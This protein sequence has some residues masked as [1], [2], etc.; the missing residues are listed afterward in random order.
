MP[1]QSRRSKAIATA[2]KAFQAVS[3]LL[4][5]E[6]LLDDELET[7]SLDVNEPDPVLLSFLQ[8]F[9]RLKRIKKSRYYMKR[10]WRKSSL[11]TTIF[12]DDL[13]VCEDGS[14]WMNEDEFKRKYRVSRE[15]LDKITATIENNDVFKG[16]RGPDQLPVKY[17]LMI[18]LHYLGKEGESNAS[19]RD[20]FKIAYGSTE[21]ARERVVKALND[22]RHQYITW[23]D[24]EERKQIARRIEKE[25]HLP[26]CVGF[27]DGTLLPLGIAPSSDDAADYHGRKFQYSLTVLVINDDKRRIRAYLSGYPGSTHDNRLWRNMKQNQK[28]DQYFGPTEYVLCDTA[29]ESSDV[30]VSAYKHD[31]GFFTDPVKQHFNDIMS[32][33]RVITEHTMGMWKGRMPFLRNIR[34]LITNQKESLKRILRYIEASV[35][36]HNMLIEFG[37]GDETNGIVPWDIEEETLSDIGDVTRIPER[38]VLDLPLPMGSQSGQRREQLANYVREKVVRRFNYRLDNSADEESGLSDLDSLSNS[39][40]SI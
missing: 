33:P 12:E 15:T 3:A 32:P 16:E 17:Q 5:V 4:I 9:T 37:D 21:K 24:E 38:D 25:F 36:L 11:N 22:L 14:H 8:S 18:L 28:S 20:Q 34:M 26:N 10:F 29:F 1:R 39:L 40:M 19:Q 30:C 31:A 35:V 13:R 7:F 27:M 2:R 23:P 6:R